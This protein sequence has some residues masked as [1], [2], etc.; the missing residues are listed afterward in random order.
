MGFAGFSYLTSIEGALRLLGLNP[1]STAATYSMSIIALFV[2]VGEFTVHA[3]LGSDIYKAIRVRM[4][5]MRA[6]LAMATVGGCA[7]FDCLTGSSV[8]P[9]SLL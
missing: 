6:G 5:H 8:S 7:L 4:G 2:L 9:R 1:I 3:G